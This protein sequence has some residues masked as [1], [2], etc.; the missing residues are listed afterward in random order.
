MRDSVCIWQ[1]IFQGRVGREGV[2]FGRALF[3]GGGGGGVSQVCGVDFASAS[4]AGMD[5]FFAQAQL[6]TILLARARCLM[7]GHVLVMCCR[8]LD[9]VLAMFLV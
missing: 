7:I 9:D 3:A 4:F 2:P 6:C 8:W 1:H 5:R